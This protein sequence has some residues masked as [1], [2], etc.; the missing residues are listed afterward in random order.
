MIKLANFDI[1]F[2]ALRYADLRE[3]GATILCIQVGTEYLMVRLEGEEDLA[4]RKFRAEND[5]TTPEAQIQR[6]VGEFTN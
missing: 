6:H 3:P 1:A 4:Y 5:P 2:S